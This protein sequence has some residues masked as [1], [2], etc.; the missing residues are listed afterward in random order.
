MPGVDGYAFIEELRRRPAEA[1]GRIPAVA[2]TAHARVEDRAR[3]L[4]AG[5]NNH[6]PKPVEP[7]ELFAV[8]SALVTRDAR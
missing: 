8:L 5:F 6:V 7:L 3:A 4:Y 2:L 1:G